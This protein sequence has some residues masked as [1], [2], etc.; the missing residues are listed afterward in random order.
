MRWSEFV[1]RIEGEEKYILEFDEKPWRKEPLGRD[2]EF[3]WS[4]L[5]QGQLSGY[6]EHGI[7]Y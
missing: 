2:R 5:E 4:G 3:D 1:A 6:C 7:G